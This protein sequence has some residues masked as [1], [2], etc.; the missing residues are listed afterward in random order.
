[1]FEFNK[2]RKY[3]VLPRDAETPTYSGAI[4]DEQKR[5]LTVFWKELGTLHRHEDSLFNSRIQTFLLAT[6]FLLAA[7]SQFR[8]PAYARVQLLL[9]A[10]GIGL[11]IVFLIVLGRT[12]CT[13]EWYIEVLNRLDEVLFPG[14]QQPYRTRRTRTGKRGT[15]EGRTVKVPVSAILGLVLPVSVILVWCLLSYW[16]P[17]G[18]INPNEGPWSYPP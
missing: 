10:S 7:F 17:R 4:S 13:I 12:A 18:E 3:L 14:D 11:S 5:N 8:E 6:S 15:L 16:I 2:L 9:G 1:M